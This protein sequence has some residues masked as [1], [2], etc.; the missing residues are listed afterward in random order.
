MIFFCPSDKLLIDKS[1]LFTPTKL[2]SIIPSLPTNPEKTD[3]TYDGR[4]MR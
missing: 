4:G 3:E 1:H 2:L